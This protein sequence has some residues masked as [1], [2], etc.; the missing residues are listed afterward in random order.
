MR[1]L[2]YV[3]IN[4]RLW[5]QTRVAAKVENLIYSKVTSHFKP[6]SRYDDRFYRDVMRNNII[7]I[8]YREAYRDYY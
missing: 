6:S 3:C 8:L 4:I 1:I 5:D 7:A 2:E